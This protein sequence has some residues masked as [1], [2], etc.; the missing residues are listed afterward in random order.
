MLMDAHEACQAGCS[1]PR[2]F[3]TL[4]FL[5]RRTIRDHLRRARPEKILNC[6]PRIHLWFFRAC[7]LALDRLGAHAA[8]AAHFKQAG[9]LAP[10]N[11]NIIRARMYERHMSA[12]S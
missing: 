6:I 2:A 12:S 7:G 1:T 8:A 3:P 4:T 10:H 11:L 9:E 5:L